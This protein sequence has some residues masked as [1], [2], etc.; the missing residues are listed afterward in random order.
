MMLHVV[1]PVNSIGMNT[2]LHVLC[3]ELSF[4]IRCNAVQKSPQVVVL[5]QALWA[6]KGKPYPENVS[7]PVKMSLCPPL[8][9]KVQYN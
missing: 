7:I 3:C 5:A 2:L 9:E 1:R 6:G 8:D 4:W